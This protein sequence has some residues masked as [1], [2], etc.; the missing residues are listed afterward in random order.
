MQLK[1][2]KNMKKLLLGILFIPL[3]TVLLGVVKY[4]IQLNSF[5]DD[6]KFETLEN[7][8][9][10]K[11]NKTEVY[12]LGTVHFETEKLK[13]HHFYNRIDSISP[14][15]IL[16]EGIEGKVKRMVK[17]TDYIAQFMN[18]FKK[19]KKIESAVVLKYISKNPNCKVSPYEWVNRDKYHRKYSLR[20]KSKKMINAVLKL[21][22]N[23]LL[24][25]EETA[26]IDS[27]LVI[28]KVLVT[29]DNNA[30]INAINTIKLYLKI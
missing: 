2:K 29:I 13:R 22:T 19:S 11:Q 18:A 17:R 25:K 4:N 6:G 24:N 10:D 16:Y 26:V 23:K 21:Y 30:T 9:I 12:I 28:N 27:F 15:I 20:K 3:T 7:K 14:N 8:N 5:I 1:F